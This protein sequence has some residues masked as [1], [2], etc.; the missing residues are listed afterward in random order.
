VRLKPSLIIWGIVAIAVLALE[1]LL[2][3]IDPWG[4]HY[5]DDLAYLFSQF[6]EDDQRGYVLPD[7]DYHFRRWQATI[8]NGTRFLPD[9]N[10]QADCTIVL[11]GDSVAFGYGVHDHET[12]ANL[13]AQAQPEVQVVNTGTVAYNSENVLGTLRAFPDADAYL[14]VIID[15]DSNRALT[16]ATMHAQT[17]ARPNVMWLLR[18]L[19]YNPVPDETNGDPARFFHDLAEITQDE[20]VTLV[21]FADTPLTQN[22]I[23]QE[24]AITSI[25]DDYARTSRADTHANADGNRTLAAQITP[26]MDTMVEKYCD[27]DVGAD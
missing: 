7:G 10:P 18:Y 20:R 12:W 27:A 25:S 11:L 4:L 9:T 2:R 23:A 3:V 8:R 26:I 24:Y 5:F 1:F 19:W 22:I 16:A 17:D 15:N 6:A 21:G 13:V 14:Y